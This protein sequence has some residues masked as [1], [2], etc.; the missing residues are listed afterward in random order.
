MTMGS[1]KQY[2]QVLA[3]CLLEGLLG[4]IGPKPPKIV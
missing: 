3:N 1:N 4:P 2:P